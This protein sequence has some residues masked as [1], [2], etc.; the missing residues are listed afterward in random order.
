LLSAIIPVYPWA[1]F[2]GG[3]LLAWRFNKS[4]LFFALLVLVLADQSL[5]F[6]ADRTANP[7]RMA[8]IVSNAVPLLLPLNLAVFSLLKE[9]GIVTLRGIF[10]LGLILLQPLGIALAYRR[11]P[12]LDLAGY[13]GHSFV[14]VSALAHISLT[15]PA[16]LAFF[17]AF[18]FLIVRFILCRDAVA[19]TFFWTLALVFLALGFAKFEPVFP[20][21]FATAG[22]VLGISVIETSHS[23]AYRDEL[24]QLPARRALK[25]ALLKL[26]SRYTVAMIDI[27]YF[28]KFNDRYGHDV[29]DQVLQ[30][31]ASKL[32]KVGRGGKAFRYGGEEFVLIFPG[33]LMDV[34]PH[35][36]RV[37]KTIE[38]SE[39]ILRGPKRPRKKPE[40]P[41]K[42]EKPETTEE[43][44]EKV[45]V[46]VSIGVAE[47]DDYYRTP[48]EVVK[49]ADEAMYRAKNS[50]RN[51]IS[52]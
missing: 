43:F 52:A 4:R 26:G 27:D 34:I 41:E 45:S 3:M 17:V 35:V 37:R 12:D 9:R 1:V 16:L 2:G 25:E 47:R 48:R 30:M 39:F 14:D 19:G 36:E 51:R 42:L 38:S 15:Q 18:L 32:V 13:L 5:Q 49:A 50:G 46:T 22:L 28:K 29:G 21:F 33:S 24:T 23:M 20:L 11:Y 8:D 44:L 40:K 6:F 31:V 7:F 10:R